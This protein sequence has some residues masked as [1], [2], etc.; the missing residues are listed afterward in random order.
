LTN[1][2]KTRDFF[3]TESKPAK[4]KNRLI[5][6]VQIIAIALVVFIILYLIVF[7]P[8]QVDGQSM[9]PNFFDK[10]LIFTDKMINY[11]GLTDIG[12]SLGYEYQ[13]GDAVVFPQ[14]DTFLIKRIIATSGDK[15]KVE[16]DR[17]YLNGNLLDEEYIDP[18]KKPTRMPSSSLATFLEGEEA[19]VP[20]D[21]YFLLGDNRTNSKDSR[22]KS[23]NFIKRD[24]LV[25]RV[26][27]R[28]WPLNRFGFVS[29]GVANFE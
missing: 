8:N 19:I 15:V 3:Y 23:V 5:L 17:V 10:E 18:I 12:K 9:E 2:F 6:F 11:F 25:G 16:N 22:Y 1:D 27:F 28:F 21:S 29:K 26:F 7:I 24:D 14:G 13:R 4:S 20:K